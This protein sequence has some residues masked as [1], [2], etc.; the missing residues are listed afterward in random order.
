MFGKAKEKNINVGTCVSSKESGVDAAKEAAEVAVKECGMQPD[1]SIVYVDSRYNPDEICGGINSILG[2]NWVGCSTDRQFSDK[3]TIAKEKT[4]MVM[5]IKSNYLHFGVGAV[6]NYRKD[7]KAAGQKAIKEAIATFKK[8]EYVNPYVQFRRAQTKSYS[9]IV[10]TPPYFIIT[11]LSGTMFEN[12]KIILGKENDFL[13]GIFDTVG[14]NIPVFGSVSNSDFDKFMK[15]AEGKNY[16]FAN[17]KVLKG[18]AITLFVSSSLLFSYG[19][20]HGYKETNISGLITKVI[21][22]QIVVEING[23]PAIDEYCKM[24]GVN[25]EDF[26]KDPYKYT[27]ARSIAIMDVQGNTYIRAM[28]ITPDKKYLFSQA[29]LPARAAFNIVEYEEKS[30]INAASNA[31][32]LANNEKE[33]IAFA[34]ISS[35]S[36]RKALLGDKIK[37]E[38]SAVKKVHGKF[39]FMGFYTFGEIGSNINCTCLLNEQS[40]TLLVVYDKLLSE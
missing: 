26:L 4:V 21:D 39:P 2:T 1:F 37:D 31:L 27:L 11:F 14:A 16:Q 5:S 6:E 17:G 8:D 25:K 23:K 20:E 36:S 22:G 28:G 7:P 32:K 33:Q 24:I 9:E 18:G 30:A 34:L 19:L 12:K 40:V 35:C 15:E 10:R 38:I 3:M 29:K 13:S